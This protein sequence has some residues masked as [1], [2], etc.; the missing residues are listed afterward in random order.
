MGARAGEMGVRILTSSDGDAGVPDAADKGILGDVLLDAD[1]VSR[2]VAA[3]RALADPHDRVED[4]LEAGGVGRRHVE[5]VSGGPG[6][7]PGPRHVDL[8]RGPVDAE[9]AGLVAARYPVGHL[10]EDAGVRVAGEA[11][12]HRPA[13]QALRPQRHVVLAR[14]EDRPVVVDVAHDHPDDRGRAQATCNE[15]IRIFFYSA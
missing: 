14:L 15:Q 13:V 2:P 4:A 7:A 1:A 5:H 10:P 9:G 8:T 3:G 12:H 6:Q 11:A